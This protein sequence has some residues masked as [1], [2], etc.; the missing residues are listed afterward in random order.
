MKLCGEN[1]GKN[2]EY[3][4]N[5]VEVKDFIRLY[6]KIGQTDFD[7]LRVI[8]SW[9]NEGTNIVVTSESA[10]KWWFFRQSIAIA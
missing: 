1:E 3:F 5:Y 7:E 10:Y 4:Y 8:D 2:N 6:Q 9:Y